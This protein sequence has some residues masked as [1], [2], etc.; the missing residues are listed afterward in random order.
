MKLS[1]SVRVGE[2]YT[3]KRQAAVPL[4]ELADI[5]LASGYHALCMRAS[6][7]GIQTPRD[8]VAA[9]ARLL[10]ERNLRVSMITGDFPIPENTDDGPQAL[11]NIGPYL[12]LAQAL[13]SQLVRVALRKEEDIAWAQRASDA[14][15]ERGITLTHQ[16]H[17]RS[18]FERID[19]TL[20]VLKRIGRTNFGL[21]YEPANLEC[22]GQSYGRETLKRFA[23]WLVNVYLQNQRLNPAGQSV[24][25]TW[26]C[27]DVLF[28]QAPLWDKSGINFPEIMV[29][30]Q[31]LEYTGYVTVHQAALTTPRE[32]AGKNAQYLRSIGHFEPAIAVIAK[33]V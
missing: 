20:D 13:D 33:A 15:R 18:L 4:S 30:L 6:Q 9:H 22:C 25:K 27:G 10:R 19:E 31:E 8:E 32:D 17:N 28:D 16:S 21:T 14:A 12:D 26:C 2:K 1:L 11:R 7:I 3:D 29:A 23:P 24:M 5:A